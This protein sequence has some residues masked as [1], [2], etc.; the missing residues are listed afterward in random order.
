MAKILR[1]MPG[2]EDA[3]LPEASVVLEINMAHKIADK[4]KA[5]YETDRE[6]VKKYAKI[7]YAEACLISGISI[8]NPV[9]LTEL[10][11][12]LMV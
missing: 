1:R 4:L 6:Q 10:I 7:L 9:E 11:S 2:S 8:E 3:G 5:L 12:E